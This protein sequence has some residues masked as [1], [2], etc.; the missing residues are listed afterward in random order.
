[1]K[2]ANGSAHLCDI[3]YSEDIHQFNEDY[4]RLTRQVYDTN[5]DHL[6]GDEYMAGDAL[7]GGG[8]RD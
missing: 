4:L 1:M 6:L 7:D 8:M 5:E 2:T 3:P